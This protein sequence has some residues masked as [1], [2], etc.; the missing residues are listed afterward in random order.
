[1]IHPRGTIG[2]KGVPVETLGLTPMETL[3]QHWQYFNVVRS[4]SK[5]NDS[6]WKSPG[7]IMV[8]GAPLEVL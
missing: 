1:M 6:L 8:N 2:R 7:N 4:G 3:G 5:N